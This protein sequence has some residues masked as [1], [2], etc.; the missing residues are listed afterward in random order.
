M[1]SPLPVDEI[2]KQIRAFLNDREY[3]IARQIH[4]EERFFEALYADDHPR[5]E[6]GRVEAASTPAF[7]PEGDHRRDIA[8]FLAE[9]ENAHNTGWDE[10][11]VLEDLAK[12]LTKQ[13]R[14]LKDKLVPKAV[15][16]DG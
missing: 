7:D 15:S 5:Y 3:F 13:R 14:M 10:M 6:F 11:N 12:Q 8:E 4:I 1:R 16:A 9:L 2:E